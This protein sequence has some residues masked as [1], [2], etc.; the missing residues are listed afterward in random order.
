VTRDE[1]TRWVDAYEAAWRSGEGV[2]R[3]FTP[4]AT[5][6]SAPYLEPYGGIAAI[7]EFWKRETDA[8]EVF[9]VDREIVAVEGD[10]G[11]VRLEVEYAAPRKRHY[12]DIW[13]VTLDG[14]GR[15]TA[16]EEWPFWPPGEPGTYAGGP[17]SA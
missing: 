9:M 16:F 10:T 17:S 3:L 15:C 1:L 7:E 12:R 4:D 5:Y 13:I 2:D 11:V 14:D 8:G 6:R